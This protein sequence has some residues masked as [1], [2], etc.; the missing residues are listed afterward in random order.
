[1]IFIIFGQQLSDANSEVEQAQSE[2]DELNLQKSLM[3]NKER[4]QSIEMNCSCQDKQLNK[5]QRS[6]S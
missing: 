3:E 4:L 1:M 6:H 5:T 2:L